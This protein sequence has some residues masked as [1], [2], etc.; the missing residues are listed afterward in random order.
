VLFRSNKFFALM[1]NNY[2]DATL[3]TEWLKF[4]ENK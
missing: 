4:I 2:S 3:K 1:K